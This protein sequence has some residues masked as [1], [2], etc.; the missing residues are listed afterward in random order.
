MDS[1]EE[2]GIAWKTANYGGAG[3]NAPADKPAR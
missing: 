3:G 2:D 1:P